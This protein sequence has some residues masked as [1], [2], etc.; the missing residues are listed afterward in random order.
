MLP[1]TKYLIVSGKIMTPLYHKSDL[2]KELKFKYTIESVVRFYS[3]KADYF[4]AVHNL[5]DNKIVEL[6]NYLIENSEDQFYVSY[7][8]YQAGMELFISPS[9][10]QAKPYWFNCHAYS[11][12]LTRSDT[13]VFIPV[14]IPT[15]LIESLEK[16]T[17]KLNVSKGAVLSLALI[18]EFGQNTW[19]KSYD[20]ENIVDALLS[21]SYIK[22]HYNKKGRKGLPVVTANWNDYVDALTEI[23]GEDACDPDLINK[24]IVE[25]KKRYRHKVEYMKDLREYNNMRYVIKAVSRDSHVLREDK[26]PLNFALHKLEQLFTQ[27]IDTYRH[28]YKLYVYDPFIKNEFVYYPTLIGFLPQSRAKSCNFSIP[29]NIFDWVNDQ[30]G[31]SDRL[32]SSMF[33]QALHNSV[34]GW[35]DKLNEKN[36]PKVIEN[37]GKF[38]SSYK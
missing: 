26:L 33:I 34:L 6:I 18:N 31:A 17:D 14:R 2:L 19:M 25:L 12:S 36:L 28:A 7:Y 9:K 8:S 37:L 29:K 27:N 5:P 16:I 13:N 20:H 24:F 15:V 32:R 30:S 1:Y 21:D 23:S 3:R 11:D 35:E 38:Y 10:L 4:F 22:R